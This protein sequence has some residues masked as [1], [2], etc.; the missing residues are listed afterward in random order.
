M[1]Q[2]RPNGNTKPWDY[3]LLK[4]VRVESGKDFC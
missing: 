4:K 2:M 1:K 3:K